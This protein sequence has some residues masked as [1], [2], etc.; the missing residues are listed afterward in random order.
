MITLNNR[1]LSKLARIKSGRPEGDIKHTEMLGAFARAL[2]YSNA[3]T[4][5]AL[6][7][8]Q[9]SDSAKDEISVPAPRAEYPGPVVMG[10]FRSDDYLV[11]ARVDVRSWL[12]EMSPETFGELV[13][14]DFGDGYASDE[15]YRHLLEE[16]EDLQRIDNYLGLHPESMTGDAVGFTVSIDRSCVDWLVANR[17]DMKDTL[18]RLRKEEVLD[19]DSDLEPESWREAP[20]AP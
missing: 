16:S 8:A 14:E 19:W 2:G 15:A 13:S 20:P 4:M 1:D 18:V 3:P 7:K 6:A 5:M 9:T 12:Q 10:D 11:T 17:P